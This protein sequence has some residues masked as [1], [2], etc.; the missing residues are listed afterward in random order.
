MTQPAA[1]DSAAAPSSSRAGHLALVVQE[2]L[3]ATVRLRANRQGPTDAESFRAHLKQLIARADQD[4]RQA[5]YAQGDVRY[6]LYAVVAF[7]DE[8]ILNSAQP[9]FRDWPRRPLQDELFG[10]HVGGEAFFQYLQQLMTRDPSPDLADVLEVYL[11]CLLLGF[12]GRYS[13]TNRDE[14]GL[15][16][17]RVREQVTRI[18]GGTPPI[19]PDW[20]IPTG[21]VVPRTRDPW[22][23]RLL[24]AG[25]ATLAVA[26]ALF[27][28]YLVVLRSGST[29][30]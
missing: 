1:I 26:L 11:L 17:S 18:R 27:V 14:L 29:I 15:W 10:G 21:E 4:A 7:I 16:T 5:G 22:L 28:I 9:M 20:A 6:A 3:T 30:A 23:R 13:A 2:L 8:S 24:F 12:Q 19:A 25:A